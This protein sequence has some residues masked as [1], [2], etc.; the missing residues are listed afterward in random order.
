MESGYKAI[1]LYCETLVPAELRDEIE[2]VARRDG[3]TVTIVERRA[4]ED[5]SSASAGAEW[6]EFDVALLRH[7]AGADRWTL[8]AA[9]RDG[10]WRLHLG[11]NG[12][13]RID[14][15]LAEIQADPTGAFWG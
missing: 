12:T 3:S 2:I 5:G 15:L 4:P 1:E 7:A 6:I 13:E 11:T 10:R 8:Y 14:P 9:D